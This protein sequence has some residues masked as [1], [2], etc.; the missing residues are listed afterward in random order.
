[1]AVHPRLP[2]SVSGMSCQWLSPSFATV[3]WAGLVVVWVVVVV[4]AVL[5][6]VAAAA[7][8]GSV[9]VDGALRLHLCLAM[10]SG[11]V[12]CYPPTHLHRLDGAY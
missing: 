8:C 9:A 4:V 6:I 5:H 3:S 7:A 11:V 2:H 1:M 12:C 10:V